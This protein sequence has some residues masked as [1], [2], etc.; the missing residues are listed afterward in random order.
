MK[1]SLLQM[2]KEADGKKLPLIQRKAW[3]QERAEELRSQMRDS[4]LNNFKTESR[5]R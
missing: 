2:E 4:Q 3:L 1:N 5:N